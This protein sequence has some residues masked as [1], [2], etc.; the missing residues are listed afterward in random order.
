L[1]RSIL[2]PE[3]HP[4]IRAVAELAG[5]ASTLPPRLQRWKLMPTKL[6]LAIALPIALAFAASMP[7]AAAS[8]FARPLS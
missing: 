8:D 3:F 7:C 4:V 1:R 5:F 2:A 6:Q